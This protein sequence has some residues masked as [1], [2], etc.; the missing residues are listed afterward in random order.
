MCRVVRLELVAA[1]GV[2]LASPALAWEGPQGTQTTLS[3]ETRVQNGHT[4]AAFAVAVRGEDGLP[5]SGAV[6]I[7]EGGRQLAGATLSAEGQARLEFGLPPGQHNLS[8]VYTG[9]AGHTA[10]VSAVTQSSP[11]A[12]VSHRSAMRC[13]RTIAAAAA[14]PRGVNS[15]SLRPLSRTIPSRVIR[16]SASARAD[17]VLFGINPVPGASNPM[18]P[19]IELRARIVQVRHMAPEHRFINARPKQRRLALVSIGRADGF[20]CSWYPKTKLQAI[21]CLKRH[22]ARR[23]WRLL[24]TTQTPAAPTIS[25]KHS[26]SEIPTFT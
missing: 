23:I 9:D 1:L 8:A 14:S 13:R 26:N 25:I 7:E 15:I 2:A 10:S 21:R 20:P 22:L 3:A 17:S 16:R 24:Y 18:L 19:V 12:S 5:A 11:R 6:V 4:V